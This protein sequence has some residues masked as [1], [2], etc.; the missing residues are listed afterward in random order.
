[1]D[2]S[3]YN[4]SLIIDI[5]REQELIFRKK[6][7]KIKF[8]PTNTSLHA[9]YQN[10]KIT[11][12]VRYKMK[13]NII[14]IRPMKTSFLSQHFCRIIKILFQNNIK[15]LDFKII[16]DF[17][18]ANFI[19]LFN[20]C[21]ICGDHVDIPMMTIGTC[22]K[23]FCQD[24]INTYLVDNV[25]TESYHQ[26]PL[27]FGFLVHTGLTIIY[28]PKIDQVFDPFPYVLVGDTFSQKNFQKLKQ[29]IP[30]RTLNIQASD[31]NL[32]KLIDIPN[33]QAILED[34]MSDSILLSQI[35]Q[36]F[37]PEFY[38]YLKFLLRTNQTILK[39]SSLNENPYTDT[40]TI[41]EI[42]HNPAIEEKFKTSQPEYL[43]HGSASANWYSILR[44]G[45]KNMSN[46]SLMVNG[47]AHGS[48]I[49]LSSNYNLS[50]NYSQRE[51]TCIHIVGVVQIVDAQKYDKGSNIYV[52]PDESQ[53]IL[54]FLVIHYDT[55][56]QIPT[57]LNNYFT[58]TVARQYMQLDMEISRLS[59]KRLFSEYQKIIK[60]KLL[61]K[62]FQLTLINDNLS[63]WNVIFKGFDDNM[64]D[65]LCINVIFNDQYPLEPPMIYIVKPTIQPKQYI[66]ENGVLCLQ[67]LTLKHWSA[68]FNLECL[69]I[70]IRDMIQE[71]HI[72]ILDT[73]GTYQLEPAKKTFYQL[74][75]K[76]KWNL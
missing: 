52:V 38:G 19:Q 48:G 27:V 20:F 31:N 16:L 60:N 58:K 22:K 57:K 66:L 32:S 34:S 44:N 47:N 73:N 8:H 55:N 43:F 6:Q 2:T 54:R 63:Q 64:L 59:T 18:N 7:I 61:Q 17:L 9:T 65:G 36:Q 25:V 1:M 67:I 26:D 51:N 37:C 33:L 21:T 62:L 53:I 75:D 40:Y 42:I 76:M 72:K 24:K 28:H 68:T 29:I 49:Y 5:H 11:L 50:F 46:T 39:T 35:K 41:L 56:Y 71:S 23:S 30:K 4:Y 74:I 14:F 12:M 15:V 69:L 3:L 45:L 10:G 70:L 13:K